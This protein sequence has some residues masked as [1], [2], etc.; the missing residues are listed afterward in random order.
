MITVQIVN[1]NCAELIDACLESLLSHAPTM[2][3]ELLVL[4][5]LSRPEERERIREVATRHGVRLVESPSNLGFGKGHNAAARE[6]RGEWIVILNPDILFTSDVLTPLVD[7]LAAHPEVGL[8]APRL[9]TPEGAIQSSWNVAENLVWEFAK[10]FY[11]QGVWRNALERRQA[12]DHGAA[13][14]W[15]VG[16]VLGAFMMMRRDLFLE[17]GGFHE[18]F[19]MNGEDVEFCDRIR[20]RGLALRYFPRLAIVH[21]EGGTQRRDWSNYM[22]HRFQAFR[23]YIELRYT[24]WRRL[25]AIGLWHLSLAI[26]VGAGFILF[27]GASRTRLRGYLQAW[28]DPY[29]RTA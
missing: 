4:D 12:R 3:M 6:A 27:R 8:V 29:G 13:P 5:N 11:L 26:R 28:R 17:L 19:F 15:D 20:H 2:P 25:V 22:R 16:Y 24:G 9:L 1:W 7:H 10:T 23:L 18:S 14:W 21:D